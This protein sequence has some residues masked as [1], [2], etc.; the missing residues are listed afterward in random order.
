MG[1]I[2]LLMALLVNLVVGSH[3][4]DLVISLVAVLLFT[5]ITAYDAQ[6]IKQLA[7]DPEIRASADLTLKLSILGALTLY[8]DFINLF[9]QL[10][11]LFG[12]SD[13]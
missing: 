2:G 7:S 12:D 5:G 3:P 4:L 1:L 11:N 6:K 10:L 9:L 13:S 8:L